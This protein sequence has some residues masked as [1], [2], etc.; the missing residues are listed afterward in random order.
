MSHSH[1]S[2]WFYCVLFCDDNVGVRLYQPA[3]KICF[4]ADKSSLKLT[5]NPCLELFIYLAKS[6]PP[7]SPPEALCNQVHLALSSRCCFHFPLQNTGA[8]ASYWKR[9][10]WLKEK[11]RTNQETVAEPPFPHLTDARLSFSPP[12]KSTAE[13]W[14]YNVSAIKPAVAAGAPGR[15]CQYPLA[16]DVV[17]NLEVNIDHTCANTHTHHWQTRSSPTK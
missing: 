10:P 14:G 7:R 1:P 4:E 6:P 3:C 15:C 2:D 12:D 8:A 11:M 17:F 16:L 9:N 5:I 13:L